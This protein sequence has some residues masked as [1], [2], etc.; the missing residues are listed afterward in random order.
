LPGLYSSSIIIFLTSSLGSLI[1]V[2]NPIV[3]LVTVQSDLNL[4]IPTSI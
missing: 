2:L 1:A 4:Y 3:S